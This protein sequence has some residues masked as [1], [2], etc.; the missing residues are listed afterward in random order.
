MSGLTATPTRSPASPAS[1]LHFPHSP[2]M[3]LPSSHS[4]EYFLS[5]SE[6][7]RDIGKSIASEVPLRPNLAT[8]RRQVE[9]EEYAQMRA[10]ARPS[11]SA[12][13]ERG[14]GSRLALNLNHPS[15]SYYHPRRNGT[16]AMFTTGAQLGGRPI[17][18]QEGTMH[19]D[20]FFGVAKVRGGA[21]RY[22]HARSHRRPPHRA[23]RA[24]LGIAVGA[25]LPKPDSGPRIELL[26]DDGA[27]S[28]VPDGTRKCEAGA[29]GVV[30]RLG[31]G[32][33]TPKERKAPTQCDFTSTTYG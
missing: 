31:L 29:A 5:K 16:R 18:S 13:A 4:S 19:A 2:K 14:G 21:A 12:A 30:G 3:T 26:Q 7:M 25:P 17:S 1:V 27:A 24:A 6:F 32:L 22:L 33:R 20:M 28:F 9:T 11:T 8:V 23:R 10:S 15:D